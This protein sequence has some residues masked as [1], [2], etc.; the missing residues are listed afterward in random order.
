MATRSRIGLELAD[1]SILSAYHHWDGYP[2]WLGRILNTHYNTKFKVAE[3]I[4]GGDMSS[5][6]T[7]ERWDSETKVQEY[8][9]QYYSQRGDDCPPRL[10][11]IFK[12]ILIMVK[13]MLISLTVWASGFA[14][15]FTMNMPH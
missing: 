7:E 1:G 3:L 14:M 11:S 5:C 4:D 10:D 9:P 15:I 6:W 12:S 2:E 13:S 8:G